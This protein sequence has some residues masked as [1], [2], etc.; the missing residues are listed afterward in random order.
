MSVEGKGAHRVAPDTGEVVA[1]SLCLVAISVRT[2]LPQLLWTPQRIC[3]TAVSCSD[4]FFDVQSFRSAQR[5]RVELARVAKEVATGVSSFF[6]DQLWQPCEV[7]F[8]ILH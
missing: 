8:D 4:L 5:N 1:L 6:S 2:Y 3:V 7:S